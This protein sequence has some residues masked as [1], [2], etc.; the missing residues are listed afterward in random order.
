M[1]LFP[2]GNLWNGG[3]K[4]KNRRERSGS[5]NPQKSYGFFGILRA[6]FL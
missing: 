3:E 6:F 4:E 2:K 1:I 5:D